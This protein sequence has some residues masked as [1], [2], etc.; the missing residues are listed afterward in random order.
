VQ[1]PESACA[2]LAGGHVMEIK[3]ENT[4]TQEG[5]SSLLCILCMSREEDNFY[6]HGT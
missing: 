4:H 6:R 2:D 5:A 3:V 1:L